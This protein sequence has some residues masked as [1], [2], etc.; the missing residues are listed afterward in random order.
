[1]TQTP[2][3]LVCD[4]RGEGLADTLRPLSSAGFRVE[5]SPSLGK[6]RQALLGPRAEVVVIE[7]LA[8]GGAVELD[9]LGRALSEDLPPV[10][11]VADPG[12]PVSAVL[13]ARTLGEGLWD[14]VRRDAPL[15]EFLM[16]IEN[17]RGQVEERVEL[18]RMRYRAVHDDRTELLR[19]VPF[20][21][22][23]REHFS[24]AQRHHFDLAL[25]LV[26]LDHFGSVNKDF[27]H[28]V[29]DQVITRVGAVV[30]ST[31]R[32]EDVGGRL[33]GDEFAVVLPYTRRVDAARVV[34]RLC[35]DIRSLSGSFED[36]GSALEVT[37]SLGFETYDGT[38]LESVETLRRHAEVALK[39]AKLMGGDRGLYF[40]SLEGSEGESPPPPLEDAE[41]SA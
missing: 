24:A 31:L 29:G 20:Q 13:A 41:R 11:V 4:H 26:D 6:T 35:E 2:L 34:S 40:R 18:A 8:R 12:E 5:V 37:A 22:R 10:L 16:R 28:T 36:C 27:D 15:E 25:V 14:V 30:R 9:L 7:P 19:P 21:A 3:I 38:D 33:G 17:L 23:L 39:R 32:A 1:M